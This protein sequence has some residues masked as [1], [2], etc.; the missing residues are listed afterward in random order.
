MGCRGVFLGGG[1]EEGGGEK[2]ERGEILDESERGF[3][4]LNSEE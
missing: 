1:G 4:N 3:L 2:K